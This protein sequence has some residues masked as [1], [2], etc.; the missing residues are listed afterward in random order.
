MSDENHR[1]EVDFCTLGMF[2][3]D[4]IEFKP[5]TPSV[6]G[7]IGG[8][9]SFA[10]VGARIVA[11][12]EH[13]KAVSWIV[14][15]GSDFPEDMMD[16]ILS[17]NTG[18]AI[19]EDKDRLTTRAWNGYGEN[20]KRDFK[21]L[22]PKKRLEPYMLSDAQLLSKTFHMVCSSERCIH[23]VQEILHRRELA[24]SNQ[25][26]RPIFVWEPVPD[27]CAPEEQE[28]FLTACRVVD[29]VSPNELELG[30]MFGRPGWKETNE[31][32]REL[33]QKILQSG[34]GPENKGA[35]VIRAGK[36][37]SYSYSKGQKGL[38]LPAYHQPRPDQKSKV[39]DPTGAGNSFLGALAQGMISNDREPGRIMD[40][41]LSKSD[42]WDKIK[43]RWGNNGQIPQALICA[44]VTAG[45]VVEQIGVPTI[46]TTADGRETWNGTEFN[47]RLRNY[48]QWLCETFEQF[49][50]D[51]EWVID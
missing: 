36:D 46:S 7:I 13:G 38:W 32:D 5:P 39:V 23:I 30:M 15:T 25:S 24:S 45:F 50:Q 40:D 17:W 47:E 44:T 12:K 49:P 2:I 1:S 37:G 26:A 21:Y 28:K 6:Y 9:G 19:R 42:E 29:L 18:C 43:A 11:G 27:L 41:I 10:I 33:V 34:I 3:I 4:D 35:L 8:A 20:E 51:H 48:T 14:D 16:T 31:I 22:T